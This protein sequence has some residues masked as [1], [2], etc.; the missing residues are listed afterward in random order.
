MKEV[1]ISEFKAKC[2][3]PARSKSRRRR[4]PFCIISFRKTRSPTSCSPRFRQGAEIRLVW[5]DERH[6]RNSW[7]Y[8]SLPLMTNKIGK[9]C[10]IES[11]SCHIPLREV[12]R[13]SLPQIL[14]RPTSANSAALPP[15]PRSRYAAPGPHPARTAENDSTAASFPQPWPAQVSP[16]GSAQAEVKPRNSLLHKIRKIFRR[17]SRLF[18]DH[19]IFSQPRFQRALEPLR[20]RR[21]VL[22]QVRPLHSGRSMAVAAPRQLPPPRW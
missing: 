20:Q 22:D 3:F 1:A 8:S 14:R 11:L 9:P 2:L 17:S 5:F 21:I 4:S 7:G 10:A 6:V 12:R 16:V 13:D 18:H 15:P 19:I